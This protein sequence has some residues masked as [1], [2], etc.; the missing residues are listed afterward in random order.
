[1]VQKMLN[2][3]EKASTNFH[4]ILSMAS[5]I[6]YKKMVPLH[7]GLTKNMEI[8]KSDLKKTLVPVQ[9]VFTAMPMSMSLKMPQSGT[10]GF[11]GT[12]HGLNLKKLR[13]MHLTLDFCSCL[14]AKQKYRYFDDLVESVVFIAPR[15]TYFIL[16][17][18][19]EKRSLREAY[20]LSQ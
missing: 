9:V 13:F 17:I 12:K 11:L 8:G 7:S 16:K 15:T 19:F 14:A 6:G 10:I 18:F 5:H 20:R 4:L 1:M 3:R 2:P